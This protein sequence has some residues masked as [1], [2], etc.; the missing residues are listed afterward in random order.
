MGARVHRVRRGRA[1]VQRE[2]SAFERQ[3]DGPAFR[4]FRFDRIAGL[5]A[6]QFVPKADASAEQDRGDGDMKAI[7]QACLQVITDKGWP[8]AYSHILAVRRF[9]GLLEGIDR[10]GTQKVE[11]RAARHF[12]RGA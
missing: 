8:A 10:I 12:Q 9:Y 11:G 1:C 7:D 6:A 3:M 4:R 5:K 2:K